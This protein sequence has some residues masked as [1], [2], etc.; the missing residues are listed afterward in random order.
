MPTDQ[1]VGKTDNRRN[2][3]QSEP[4]RLTLEEFKSLCRAEL[5]WLVT[6]YGFGE[7]EEDT[8][9]FANPF[10][11][12]FVRADLIIHVEG[13]NYGDH[14][15]FNIRDRHGRSISARALD[16]AFVPLAK[17]NRPPPPG[18]AAEIV[19]NARLLRTLGTRLLGGDFSAF[20]EAVARIDAARAAYASRS[21]LSI[22][23][24]KAVAAFRLEQWA[25]VVELLEPYE[26]EISPR[27]GRKLG[28]AREKITD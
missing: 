27:M 11:V 22:A 28:A 5:N 10:E 20:E 2:V 14:V 16:P 24:Q 13:I 26:A 3:P 6:E 7:A 8:A 23:I 19:Y 15:L 4:K 17:T 25:R 12:Q 1:A 9:Q 18:Q 21:Q